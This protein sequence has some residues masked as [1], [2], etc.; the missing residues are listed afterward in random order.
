MM[1][2]NRLYKLFEDK[3]LIYNLQ[4]GFPQKHSNALIY[5]TD[6]IREQLDNGKYGC[7]IFVPINSFNSDLT[8]TN[9]GVPQ[10]L[11]LDQLLFFI[12]TYDSQ[13][14]HHNPCFN[15]FI[16]HNNSFDNQGNEINRNDIFYVF[17]VIQSKSFC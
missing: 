5:L 9:C 14:L 16:L 1:V 10:G 13:I 8:E 17:S 15:L 2:Y 4:F 6:K 11:I 3:K 7:G 12:H